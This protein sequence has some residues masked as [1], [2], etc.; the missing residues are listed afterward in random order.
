MT[1]T[2]TVTEVTLTTTPTEVL[3]K[4]YKPSD[5]AITKASLQLDL[6]PEATQVRSS[7]TV[8]RMEVS[9]APLELR[10]DGE[11]FQE[12]GALKVAGRELVR[13]TDFDVPGS[14]SNIVISKD[15]LPVKVGESVVVDTCVIINP[16]ANKQLM[17]LYLSDGIYTTQCEAEGFRRISPFLD[18]PD[19]MC[20]FDV[21]LRASKTECPVLLSNGNKISRRDLDD[22]RHEAVF[23]D[24]WPKP[25]Y[26]VAVVAGKLESKCI[27]HVRPDGRPVDII[28]W[29][30][31]DDVAKLEWA[32]E[33]AK[34]AFEWDEK[35]FGRIYD[36]DVFHVVAVADFNMGAMENKGL[37]IFNTS[38]LLAST[39]TSSDN[40][41]DRILGVVGHEYF[42]N[43]TGN[44][45]T[46]RDW[47]QL[48]LKE[49]LTVYRDQQFSADLTSRGMTRVKNVQLIKTR[50]FAEA[51]GPLSH[52]IRPESYVAM[53]N[54]YTVTVYWKGAEV[55]RMYASL[56]GKD[57]FRKGTDLY[58]ER[59]D[60]RA[61]TCDDFR[62]A[63]ADANGVNLDQFGRWYSTA[64]TPTVAVESRVDAGVLTLKMTQSFPDTNEAVE[65]L[66]IPVRVGFLGRN[67][68]K[69]VL[70]EQ[71][72]ELKTASEEFTVANVPD[73]LVLSVLR[74][75][76]A[77]V[78]LQIAQTLEDLAFLM[79][80][81]QDPYNQWSAS[82]SLYSKTLV[83]W[84]HA[85]L[86]GRPLPE[87]DP[88]VHTAFDSLLN[89]DS[90]DKEFQ[91][92]CLTPPSVSELLEEI[93]TNRDP[94]MAD[95]VR[96]LFVVAIGA[97]HKDALM[98]KYLEL[99]SELGKLPFQPTMEQI[100]RRA[101]LCTCLGYL[102]SEES[103]RVA[104]MLKEHYDSCASMTER[105]CCFSALCGLPQFAEKDLAIADFYALA[106]GNALV[107]DKWF[108]VQAS[109]RAP[110]LIDI[111]RQLMEHTDFKGS[112]N[113]NRWVA[114]CYVHS[115]CEPYCC[116]SPLPITV[117]IRREATS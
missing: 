53:D 67:S 113:P 72:F 7:L 99:R 6:A 109:C 34:K 92:T 5:Y 8:V 55:I 20:L 74:D 51:C 62:A 29:A 11:D 36:L 23:E 21:T 85:A 105:L 41:Y 43:W 83:E 90:E 14:G 100:G 89:A 13:G 98:A 87:I 114:Q 64:Y 28:L 37:N 59:F 18:R 102:A 46:C 107:V 32:L 69:D 93:S 57:G 108:A 112:L 73:D 33:S 24:P 44:R 39:K 111:V 117:S 75:F 26:L 104:T 38:L 48:T 84:Y 76:S 56:L 70:P 3:R 15:L 77:P 42:H 27:Q 97:K 80:N 45:V 91:G 1:S 116:S 60:G 17:G 9:G 40:D 52:P 79:A 22:G 110:C 12:I 101:L 2:E 49:G 103:Q 86:E 58:F 115:D 31:G 78:K 4:D 61:V 88:I 68:G 65:P 82:R 71:V 54:F 94:I 50:Q 10:L 35:E 19:V 95:K 66:H 25:S 96:R 30:Q 16:L 63:M 106:A 47:F 81:D